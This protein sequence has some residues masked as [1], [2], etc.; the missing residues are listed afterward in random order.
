MDKKSLLLLERVFAAEIDGALSHGL[1]LYQTKSKLAQQLEAEGY[2]VKETLELAGRFPVIVK[3]YRLT[4]L[5]NF[6]YC[7]SD[8]CTDAALPP[9]D[10]AQIRR[11]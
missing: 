1:G 6:T 11:T 2:L 10:S 9:R 3:G 8:L 7:M 4:L 5:G